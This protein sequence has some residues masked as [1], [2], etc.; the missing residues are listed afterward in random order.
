M[1]RIVQAKAKK[2]VGVEQRKSLYGIYH[3]GMLI[4]EGY[5]YTD[6][7]GVEWSVSIPLGGPNAA[8]LQPH[9]PLKD[10]IGC[11]DVRYF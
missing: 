11:I 1:K 2:A 4:Y 7:K 10:L 6:T 5:E 9:I 3:T 8:H